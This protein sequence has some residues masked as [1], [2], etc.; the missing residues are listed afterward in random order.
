MAL[1]FIDEAVI[2]VSA[3]KG[4][5]G[6]LAF[7]R[8]KH[9]PR[10]GPAGGN[11]GNGGDVV[12]VADSNL[13]TLQDHAY[14][15]HY[16]AE[17]GAPGGGDCMTGRSGE[18][19]LVPVPPGTLVYDAE[20]GRLLADLDQPGARFVAA[21]GGRGGRGNA[22]F[23]TPTDRA[24]RKWEPGEPGEVRKLR[25]ELKVLAD[26]GLVGLPNAGKSTFLAAVSRARPKVADYPFTTLRPHLGLVALD[27]ERRFVMADLPGLVEGA[28][29]GRGLG[30]RF[31]KHVERTKVLVHL[32]T[33]DADEEPGAVLEKWQAL[34]RELER[35]QPALAE[36]PELVVLTKLDL[37]WVAT[38][39][40][41]VEG[42]F[43]RRGLRL[44][45][46]SAATGQGVREVLEAIWEARQTADAKDQEQAGPSGGVE[47]P[48]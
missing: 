48:Q 21:R 44:L 8:E 22:A 47:A 18:D 35:Y 6:C 43:R 11:G 41:G 3:G 10:G 28:A 26:V 14:R 27:L 37:P 32:V 16:R 39:R 7:R 19:C 13:E 33:L 45:A 12:L 25:L 24:P 23:V 20:T 46:M 34:R 36:R 2:T 9:V 42:A 17:N 4:G 30:H 1:S 38:A 15:R 31:L 29:E 40:P 5:N